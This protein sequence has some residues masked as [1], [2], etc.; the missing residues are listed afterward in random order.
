LGTALETEKYREETIPVPG[1][2]I[3]LFFL[4]AGS[5][6]G[7]DKSF[8]AAYPEPECFAQDTADVLLEED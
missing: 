1:K 3:L 6:A 4:S 7:T 5:H 8:S 2:G